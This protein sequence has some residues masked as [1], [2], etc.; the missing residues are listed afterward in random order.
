VNLLVVLVVSGMR[1]RLLLLLPPL[2]VPVHEHL[3]GTQLLNAFLLRG[4][5]VIDK[6][7]FADEYALLVDD[8]VEL[9]LFLLDDVLLVVL[10]VIVIVVLFIVKV[11][12]RLLLL[13]FLHVVELIEDVLDLSLELLVALLHQVLQNLRHAELLGLLSQTFPS[14]DRV[15][16]A[17]HVRTHL[18]VVVLYQIVQHLQKLYA[19]VLA[20]ILAGSSQ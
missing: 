15:E 16:C 6:E 9:S 1:L 13:L 4:N 8:I 14:E 19:G 20:L 11:L 2:S 17:V 5:V 7:I 3:N 12:L 10:L 18:Q